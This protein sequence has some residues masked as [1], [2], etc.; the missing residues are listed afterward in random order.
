MQLLG[1]LR[2]RRAICSRTCRTG[3]IDLELGLKS[4]SAVEPRFLPRGTSDLF[5]ALAFGKVDDNA[6]AVELRQQWEGAHEQALQS[7]QDLLFQG[8]RGQAV[9]EPH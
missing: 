7:G 3:P 5:S 9:S 6:V 2:T 1:A 4:F 8:K